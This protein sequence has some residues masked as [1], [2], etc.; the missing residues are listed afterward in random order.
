MTNL[1]HPRKHPETSFP[2]PVPN[3]TKLTRADHVAIL[4]H[5]EEIATGH[6]DM[7]APDGSVLWLIQDS[8]RGRALFLH[9]DDAKVFR[10][11]NPIAAATPGQ[12]SRTSHTPNVLGTTQE[13]TS[14]Q[15]TNGRN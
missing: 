14:A 4:H 10:R 13:P 2:A 7:L 1:L 9:S 12:T 3:W 5:G 8:G 6:V 15:S 11:P